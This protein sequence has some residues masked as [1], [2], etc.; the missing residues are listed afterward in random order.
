MNATILVVAQETSTSG[1]YIVGAVIS[2][3]ILGYLLYTLVKPEK[4]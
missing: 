1:G 3:F 2:I 4:F